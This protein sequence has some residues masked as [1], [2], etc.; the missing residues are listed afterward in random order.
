VFIFWQMPYVDAGSTSV[1]SLH[2]CDFLPENR[3]EFFSFLTIEQK[4]A[5]KT[6]N[7]TQNGTS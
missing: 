1:N 2:E 6:M 4:Y 3:P 7:P 5:T